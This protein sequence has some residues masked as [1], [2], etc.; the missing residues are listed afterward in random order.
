MIK[1]LLM[2]FSVVLLIPLSIKPQQS[3]KN[4]A[5]KGDPI[6]L[7]K[8][9]V[10]GAYLIKADEPVHLVEVQITDCKGMFDP[11]AFTQEDESLPQENWQVAYME[12]IINAEGTKILADDFT[13]T[14]KPELWKGNV[15]MVFF[16]HYLNLEKTLRTPFGECPIP[17]ATKLPARLK[18]VKYEPPY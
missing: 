1:L 5:K 9:K 7:S 17:K 15:R 4:Y 11:I 14:E 16:M 2:F 13:A 10:I 3:F 8:I 6:Q 12:H 18:M